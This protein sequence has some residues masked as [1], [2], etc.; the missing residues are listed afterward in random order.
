[1]I[2]LSKTI[3][4]TTEHVTSTVDKIKKISQSD[5]PLELLT[6]DTLNIISSIL[7]YQVFTTQN[8]Q[9][10]LISTLLIITIIFIIG[11]KFSKYCSEKIR[12]K[13]INNSID[14]NKS[15]LLERI[16]YYIFIM[17]VAFFCLE[18]A[19]IP[20]TT[21]AILGTTIAV[22]IGIGSKITINNLVCGFILLIEH[23]IKIG[24][25]IETKSSTG[26]VTGKVEN[27]GAR[28]TTLITSDNRIVLIP[29]SNILQDVLINHPHQQKTTKLTLNLQIDIN[30]DT[31]EIDKKILTILKTHPLILKTPKPCIL[32]KKISDNIYDIDVE[33]FF[34]S[35]SGYRN[36]L[37]IS[38]LNRKFANIVKKYN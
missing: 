11:L 21:F 28:C 9:H 32:Y 3:N 31:E 17:I 30:A 20:I 26:T 8:H 38:D 35:S 2:E 13:L 27:I 14:K 33:F 29:N 12:D 16:S 1:M 4:F 34:D 10:I 6:E 25:V 37:V 36:D 18:T 7:N 22:S 24:D 15:I 5:Q 19:N 23:S